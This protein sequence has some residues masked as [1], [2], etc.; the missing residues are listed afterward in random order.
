M[1]FVRR[2][3]FFPSHIRTH[4]FGVFSLF[5]HHI[6]LSHFYYT[7]FLSRHT[8]S[9]I[10]ILPSPPTGLAAPTSL[11]CIPRPPY[12][13]GV[14]LRVVWFGLDFQPKLKIDV[15][16]LLTNKMPLRWFLDAML[17][18][19]PFGLFQPPVHPPTT[20][21]VTVSSVLLPS[22]FGVKPSYHSNPHFCGK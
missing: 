6:Q 19:Y 17:I 15:L 11:Y 21:C 22:G 13:H 8:Q 10:T 18:F 3:P 20:T 5:T 4:I 14:A 9:H 7:T 16:S 1:L 12:T 2:Y